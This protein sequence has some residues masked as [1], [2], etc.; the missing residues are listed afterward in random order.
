M[1][2][3]LEVK[4][5]QR[6]KL[7]EIFKISGVGQVFYSSTKPGAIRGNHYHTR[8][9]EKFCVIEGK[10]KIR[11]RNRETNEIKEHIVSGDNPEIVEMKPNWTHNIENI[12][13]KE[14]KLLAW[15]NEVFNPEDSDTYEEQV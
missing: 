14:M 6:G 12:G 9:I 3:K 2:E 1:N 5:D 15:V 8:K 7:I 4:Q 13:E 11:L 10:A